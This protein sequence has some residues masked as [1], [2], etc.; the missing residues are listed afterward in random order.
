MS[1]LIIIRNTL[2][3]RLSAAALRATM[4]LHAGR[5]LRILAVVDDFT[6]E[7]PCLA[8]DTSLPGLRVARELDAVVVARGRPA[9]IVSDNG[10]GLTGMAMLRWAQDDRVEWHSIAPGYGAHPNQIYGWS[11]SWWRTRRSCS[12][13]AGATTGIA[14]PRSRSCTPRS[15]TSP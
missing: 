6:R 4:R 7:C 9:A 15:G 10:T 3:F 8:A 1:D 5:R 13:L 2:C 12:R 11:G 14:M